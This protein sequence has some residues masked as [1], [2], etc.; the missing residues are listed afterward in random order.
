VHPKLM[1]SHSRE[2]N[3]SRRSDSNEP[4]RSRS[5]ST[6]R[7][8][9]SLL[10]IPGEEEATNDDEEDFT[11]DE[12]DDDEEDEGDDTDDSVRVSESDTSVRK[13]STSSISM[14]RGDSLE[15]VDS[16]SVGFNPESTAKI[17]NEANPNV[18]T[19]ARRPTHRRHEREPG[20]I[21]QAARSSNLL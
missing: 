17:P 9:T 10:H 16:K 12:D 7:R 20:A 4:P 2:Q 5:R 6:L 1:Q 8:N 3:S 13:I 11:E 19:P 15:V 21:E 14:M 18:T